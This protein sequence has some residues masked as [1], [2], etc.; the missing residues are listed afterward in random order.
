V[1]CIKDQNQAVKAKLAP[2]ARLAAG[3]TVTL[4]TLPCGDPQKNMRSSLRSYVATTTGSL[5]PLPVEVIPVPEWVIAAFRWVKEWVYV[6]H[7]TPGGV[8]IVIHLH[9]QQQQ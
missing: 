6:I 2:W 4:K 1:N 5:S 3:H 7:P 8:R 9:K